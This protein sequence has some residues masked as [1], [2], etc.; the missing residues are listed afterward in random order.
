MKRVE[1]I[2]N[3]GRVEKILNALLNFDVWGVTISPVRGCGSQKGNS[4]PEERKED[5]PVRILPFVKMEFVVKDSVVER[6]VERIAET[7]RTGEIGDGKIFI[8]SVDDAVRIR[9]GERGNRAISF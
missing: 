1:C 4:L 8:S 3:E 9:T 6:L 2:V 5:A 7:A